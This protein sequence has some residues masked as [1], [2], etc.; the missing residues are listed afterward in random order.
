M[1]T[2]QIT[3]CVFLFDVDLKLFIYF[4]RDFVNMQNVIL[5]LT[6]IL[7][8]LLKRFCNFGKK[9]VIRIYPKKHNKLG[10]VV[11]K[12]FLLPLDK[13]RQLAE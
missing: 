8:Y 9:I 12:Y 1:H 4:R 5:Y 3:F 10:R 11:A 13:R 2:H 7:L 6:K